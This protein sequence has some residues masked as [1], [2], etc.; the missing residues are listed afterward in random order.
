MPNWC[1]TSMAAAACF[2]EKTGRPEY[3]TWQ[4]AEKTYADFQLSVTNPGGHSSRRA[5]SNA[6]NQLAAALVRIGNYQLQARTQRTHP[7]LFRRGGE[8]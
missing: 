8:I 2:N 4:G 3:L 6:I 5:R 1:S 7:C